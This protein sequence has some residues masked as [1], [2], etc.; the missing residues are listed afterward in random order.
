MTYQQDYARLKAAFRLEEGRMP[1]D[2]N[3]DLAV[4]PFRSEL[5]DPFLCGSMG[6]SPSAEAAISPSLAVIDGDVREN[7]EFL[8]PVMM[9][10]GKT[11]ASSAILLFHGLNEK[12]WEKYLPWAERLCRMTGKAV[13][14]FP[15]AFH[16]NRAPASWSNP[17]VMM[18][19]VSER[20]RRF[21]P[22][23]S[24]SF[25]NVAMSTRLQF[26]PERFILS[27]LETCNDVERLMAD[28][29][30]GLNPCIEAGASIDVFGYSIGA[31]L[32]EVIMLSDPAGHFRDSRAFLFCG[33]AILGSMDPVSKYIMDG[34]AGERLISYLK[35][36]LEEELA[37]ESPLARLF[38]RIASIGTI[39]RSLLEWDRMKAFRETQLAALGRRVGALALIKDQVIPGREVERTLAACA[40]GAE[41]ALIRV[42][43]FPFPYTH[44]NPF[45]LVPEYSEDVARCFEEVFE[46]AA[47]FIG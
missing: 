19:A 40:A 47:D 17:K 25:A 31:F 33:G 2:G 41:S 9:P 35:A 18:P 39:F 34:K 15:T 20:K 28:I 11:R 4:L 3:M 32:S 38:E 5:P 37:R 43:D 7:R 26:H 21:G 6:L 36:P 10:A 1:I 24:A 46:M 27:G 13:V 16:M 30:A 12:S 14:L 23:E 42:R 22:V 44:E 45:P 8:Y 29:R